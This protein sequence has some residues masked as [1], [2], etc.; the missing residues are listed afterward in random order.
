MEGAFKHLHGILE[1]PHDTTSAAF[2]IATAAN[3]PL[4]NPVG[5]DG[6]G[7]TITSTSLIPTAMAMATASVGGPKG[8]GGDDQSECRL[9][10]SFAL[11]VQLALGGLAL[12]SLVYKRWRERPQRPIKIWFF[13]VSKQVFGSVLVHVA[14]VFMSMLT[15]GRFSIGVDSASVATMR[16]VSVMLLRRDEPPPDDGFT[17]NPCSSYLLNLAIDVSRLFSKITTPFVVNSFICSPTP[18]T[19]FR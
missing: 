19:F 18:F 6:I 2:S 14:N 7:A 17:P 12:L 9:L 5:V 11:F 13:D 16:A 1:H 4:P 3:A 15:S 10:G 8:S